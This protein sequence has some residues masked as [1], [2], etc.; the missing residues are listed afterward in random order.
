MKQISRTLKAVFVGVVFSLPL[1]SVFA[2]G[3]IDSMIDT[4]QMSQ[5]QYLYKELKDMKK[6]DI[7]IFS[8][9]SREMLNQAIGDV[10][11]ATGLMFTL[12]KIEGGFKV[13][14]D[15]KLREYIPTITP[16]MLMQ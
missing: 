11:K 5:Y 16:E 15:G 4:T 12:I 6:D 13:I 9:V 14:C 7:K 1:D 2:N 3:R 10:E 8:N